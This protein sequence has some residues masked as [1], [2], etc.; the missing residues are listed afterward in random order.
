MYS[1]NIKEATAERGAPPTRCHCSDTSNVRCECTAPF[2]C[3]LG[4]LRTRLLS[5]I[6]SVRLA[7][8]NTKFS[9]SVLR[10]DR[11]SSGRGLRLPPQLSSSLLIRHVRARTDRATREINDEKS[12]ERLELQFPV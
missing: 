4:M 1:S 12:L 6:A 11:A 5:R 8:R 10:P 2:S 9:S 3:W 7:A